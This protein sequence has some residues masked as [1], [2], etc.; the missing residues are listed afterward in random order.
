ML[1]IGTGCLQSQYVSQSQI[2]NNNSNQNIFNIIS[3]THSVLNCIKRLS[4]PMGR[5]I[6]DIA[7][8]YKRYY[9][10]HALLRWNL[11]YRNYDIHSIQLIKSQQCDTNS[12]I[13]NQTEPLIHL[14]LN[15]TIFSEDISYQYAMNCNLHNNNY[16][17]N[18]NETAPCILCLTAEKLTK[19]YRDTFEQYDTRTVYIPYQ[20]GK[21]TEQKLFTELLDNISQPPSML[22]DEHRCFRET[23]PNSLNIAYAMLTIIQYDLNAFIRSNVM[24]DANM[25]EKNQ[26]NEKYKF[27]S[28]FKYIQTEHECQPVSSVL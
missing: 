14:G 12:N 26:C 28:Q 24:M 16:N 3:H 2:I 21:L 8:V 19:C 15:R 11:Q 23:T 7:T 22:K 18:G 5:I 17:I 25:F 4:M 6:L 20:V 1:P 27:V 10:P 13:H 9:L